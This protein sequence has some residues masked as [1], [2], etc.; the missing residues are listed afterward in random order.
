MHEKWSTTILKE[1][2]EVAG[3]DLWHKWKV[4]AA[5]A[6]LPLVLGEENEHRVVKRSSTPLPSLKV[7]R[8][9]HPPPPASGS[10]PQQMTKG[11]TEE[12]TSRLLTEMEAP[13]QAVPK[14]GVSAALP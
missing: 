8:A 13:I 9:S 4:E 3:G 10:E 1:L 12:A 6:G 14:T 11:K 5:S 7:F 2:M